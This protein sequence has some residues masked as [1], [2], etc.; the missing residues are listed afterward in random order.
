MGGSAERRVRLLVFCLSLLAYGYFVYRGP[1]HNPDSRLALTYSLVER[2]TLTIDAFVGMTLDRA[3]VGGHYYTDKAPG[4]SFGLAPLYALLRSVL[5]APLLDLGTPEAPDRFVVRYLLTF[6][7]I[8]TASALFNAGLFSWM[9]VIEPRMAPRLAVTLGYALGSPVYPFSVSAFGHV[10][11][12]I[13]LGTAFMLTVVASRTEG[14]GRPAG[15]GALLGAA[16]AF[17]YPSVL[18][19]LAL[20]GLVIWHARQWLAAAG[21]LAAG[22]GGPVLL[23]AGY[24]WAAFG[25][26]L[27]VGYGHLAPGTTYAA[28]Q[29][30]GFFGVGPPD[31]RV[32]FALLFG[33]HRGLFAFAPWLALAV[34]G[35]ALL[36]RRGAWRPEV[37]AITCGCA[38]LLAVNS[39]YALW[40]GGASWGPRHLIPVLPLVAILALPAAARWPLLAW[41]PVGASVAVTLA[42]V[43][44]GSLPDSEVAAP[45]RD[46]VWPRI[47]AGGV[48]NNW[49]QVLGLAAWRGLVPLVGLTT[50]LVAAAVGWR[51][52]A[53]P[54]LLAGWTLLAVAVLDRS[55]LE[56]SEGYYLYLGSRL[57]AG[58][59]LYAE[60]ASTQPPLLPLLV[61]LLWRVQPEV[62][63][64]RLT[65]LA[66]Y[67]SAALLAGRLAARLTDVPWAGSAAAGLA[68][69]LPLAAG[70]PQ[71]LDANALLAPLAA[72][73]GVLWLAVER[74]PHRSR[75][76]L[77]LYAGLVASL[78][79]ATKLTYVPFALAPLLAVVTGS[80]PVRR[81]AGGPAS[82]APNAAALPP[83]PAPAGA[84]PPRYGDAT[85][86]PRTC[87]SFGGGVWMPS[88][89]AYLV[90]LAAGSAAQLAGWWLVSG[91]AVLDGVFGELESPV[92]PAG[93]LL[94]YFHWGLLEGV[95]VVAAVGGW[96]L[97]RRWGTSPGALWFGAGVAV[98]PAFGV[99]QGTFVGVARPAEPFV[100]AFAAVFA[101]WGWATLRCNVRNRHV[102][103]AVWSAAAVALAVGPLWY[104][105]SRL[106]VPGSIAP[107]VVLARLA[108]IPKDEEVLAPPYY[109]ALAE[110]RMLFDYADWTVWGMRAAAGVPRERVLAGVAARDLREGR[111][112]LVA[113]D[114]RLSY[115]AG[116]DEALRGAY[117]P[118]G[119][120][121]DV[122]V[123]SATF[124]RP[125]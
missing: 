21:W 89:L 67:A 60:T 82:P 43:A 64:P 95:P 16:V 62:W 120:D 66:C 55:Y 29:A 10:P 107:E 125:R 15:V 7:G 1:H 109:A 102:A 32:V 6:F 36:W 61:S 103:T 57:A 90:G 78:G 47:F 115:V 114:F 30:T 70:A 58:A 81:R 121:G 38:L 85:A 74:A 39:G 5:P 113:A 91:A 37:V 68:A 84:K 92:L 56:Y 34:P 77:A 101:A 3:Y 97:V 45:L 49:G 96:L 17:E 13:C 80:L 105:A 50:V 28:A 99:H 9:R 40:D 122:P 108:P 2:H 24:H 123:R 14:S 8:G 75:R 4:V 51:R 25:S 119:T 54:L 117:A 106:L 52:S 53:G 59:R 111:L 44:T 86:L 42:G 112:P 41:L 11:A 93:A 18:P 27:S 118:A 110:R 22:A 116:V 20:A 31:P 48:T 33:E 100:A 63:L 88:G 72:L 71:V 23:L 26:P 104:S 79:M 98:L 76:R 19:A 87:A 35:A 46:V 65:A 12:A 73:L 83:L 124:W 94:A 69:I